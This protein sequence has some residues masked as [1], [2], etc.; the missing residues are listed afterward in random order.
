[1]LNQLPL[2]ARCLAWHLLAVLVLFFLKRF[3]CLKPFLGCLVIVVFANFD[4]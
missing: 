3:C 4:T 1:L 2:R